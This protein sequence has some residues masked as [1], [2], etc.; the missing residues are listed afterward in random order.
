MDIVHALIHG[1]K[2]VRSSVGRG[3]S[4]SIQGRSLTSYSTLQGLR[5]LSLQRGA[6]TIDAMPGSGR[7]SGKCAQRTRAGLDPIYTAEKATWDGPVEQSRSS[8]ETVV[9]NLDCGYIMTTLPGRIVARTQN[10]M[11]IWRRYQRDLR[12]IA[13]RAMNFFN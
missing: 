12:R 9:E 10:C 4:S 13:D 7:L 11:R 8:A 3:F 5:G 1:R 6:N 2:A